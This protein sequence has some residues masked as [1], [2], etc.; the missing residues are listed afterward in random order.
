MN[1]LYKFEKLRKLLDVSNFHQNRI[2]NNLKKK[3]KNSSMT[4][5]TV[6]ESEL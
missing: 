5:Q 2:V 3:K 6:I 1:F 4:T